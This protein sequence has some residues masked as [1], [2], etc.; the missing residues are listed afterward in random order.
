MRISNIDIHMPVRLA[1]AT[2]AIV[3]CAWAQSGGGIGLPSPVT[4][5]PTSPQQAGS[6]AIPPRG[7]DPSSLEAAGLAG[8]TLANW[9]GSF[10]RSGTTY[11]YTMLG[12]N[13]ALGSATTTV[14]AVLIPLK[15]IFSDGT[16]LD[17]TAPIFGNSRSTEQLIEQS[18]LFQNV[19][20]APGG[21]SVGT[22]QYID[23]FQR[24]N[25]WNYVNTSAKNYHVRFQVTP[26]PV[27]TLTVPAYF[28]YT[29][30]GP[31]SR[32]GYV[33]YNW[34][35]GQLGVLLYR[36]NI[37]TSTLPMFVN[38]NILQYSPDF[39]YAGYHTAFGN[40]AQVYLS[41]GF[42]DQG[43]FTYGGDI[44]FL[45]HELGESTD[46]PFVDNIVP[47]WSNPQT[48]GSCSDLLEV[49]DPVSDLGIGTYVVNG[50]S[51]HPE[52]L[53][54]LPWF[55]GAMPST[56]VNGWYTFGN[57]YSGPSTCSGGSIR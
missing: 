30:A 12:T 41:A 56:S 49:G 32:I 38:Y 33:D 15:L 26:M 23:A 2:F 57:N 53:T 21:A 17:A 24:A 39:T 4:H 9:S 10:V 5:K 54:F 34:W 48:G 31:G 35:D 50:Y 36:L 40:P 18:P 55:S 25:F 19:A 3:G 52:D 22:T 6:A 8:T 43:L 46:D 42:F 51:Y 47:S 1:F 13:P 11:S 28:G 37:Q 7:I 29:E 27:Q 44:V 16:V 14:S 20:F 45:S